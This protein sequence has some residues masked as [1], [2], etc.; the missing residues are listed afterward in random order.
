MH[1]EIR[2]GHEGGAKKDGRKER[3]RNGKIIFFL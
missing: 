2:M 3:K 1:E